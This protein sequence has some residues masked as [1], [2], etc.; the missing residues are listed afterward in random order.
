MVLGA[1]TLTG[2]PALD[3][4]DAYKWLPQARP[5]PQGRL[6]SFLGVAQ[7]PRPSA[8]VR[9][10]PGALSLARH[11]PPSN[12]S[13]GS[14]ERRAYRLRPAALGPAPP[15]CAGGGDGDAGEPGSRP[16]RR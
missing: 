11:K 9:S 16:W 7:R 6:F 14:G 5:S 8:E 1:I 15:S 10:K 3:V 4:T 13:G 2:P 12:Y